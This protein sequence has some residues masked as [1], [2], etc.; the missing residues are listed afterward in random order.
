MLEP[1]LPGLPLAMHLVKIKPLG[2][3][4]SLDRA[5][6]PDIHFSMEADKDSDM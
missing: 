4:H 2:N 1:R 6:A 5:F 3:M